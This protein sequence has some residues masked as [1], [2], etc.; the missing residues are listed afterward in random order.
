MYAIL[1]EAMSRVEA[2]EKERIDPKE[3][4]RILKAAVLDVLDGCEDLL[5]EYMLPDDD[6]MLPE[7]SDDLFLSDD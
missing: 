5:D 7:S 1:S 6:E 4:F 2:I 3:T